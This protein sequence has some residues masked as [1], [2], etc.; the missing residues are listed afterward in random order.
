MSAPMTSADPLRQSNLA[1]I[2]RT[3]DGRF[4]VAGSNS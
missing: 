4:I 1:A 3:Q 2:L